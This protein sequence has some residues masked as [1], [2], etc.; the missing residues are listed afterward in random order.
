[1]KQIKAFSVIGRKLFWIQLGLPKEHQSLAVLLT[2]CEK[3]KT[4][5]SPTDT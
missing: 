1:M 2:V 5:N 4:W 3:G